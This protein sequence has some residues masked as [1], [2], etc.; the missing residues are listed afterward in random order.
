MA[1]E[2][3]ASVTNLLRE[4]RGPLVEALNV[5][6]VLLSEIERDG[7]PESFDGEK[8]KIPIILG[9]QQ[10]G[11]V[12]T[13]AGILNPSRQLAHDKVRV[14]TGIAHIVVS[15][16]TKAVLAA[17]GGVNAWIDAIPD[18]MEMAEE[19]LRSTIN[20]QMCGAGDALIAAITV[21]GTASTTVTVG[22]SAN[23]HQL[24]AERIVDIRNRT[25]GAVVANGV[26][27]TDFDEAAGTVT[28]DVAVTTAT[29]DGIYL[30]G[31][32]GNAIA[33]L[34]A[35]SATTGTFQ[36]L[37]KTTT[38]A[39][40]GIRIDGSSG[41]L[42]LAQMDKGERLARQRRAPKANF[43]VGGDGIIDR[44][45]QQFTVQAEWAGDNGELETG[46][47]GMKFRNQVLVREND[48]APGKLFRVPKEHMRIYTR[49]SGPDWD[50]RDGM[51][52]RFAR[53]WPFESWLA[54]HLQLGFKSCNGVVEHYSYRVAS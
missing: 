4:Q 25:T 23:F 6:T 47:T 42:T 38:P 33:G 18:K 52:K 3:F 12:G 22:T 43:Y 21:L 44:Y 30:E 13:E 50:E 9:P 37:S 10:G 24:Y 14:D 49:D 41:D 29:T 45:G 1:D 2:T 32:Y 51:F 27:I 35:A 39:W 7:S 46:W 40:R 15:W 8:V 11:G 31:T 36:E 34:G 54:W 17:A 19:G 53:S 26:T 16:T 48:I 28:V 20:E 5:S